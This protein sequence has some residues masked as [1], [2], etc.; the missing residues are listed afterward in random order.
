LRSS[1]YRRVAKELQE[2]LRIPLKKA[3]ATIK[4]STFNADFVEQAI[5]NHSD[6]TKGLRR[7]KAL[8]CN[9]RLKRAGTLVDKE[10]SYKKLTPKCLACGIRGHS[11]RDYWCLFK[12]KKPIGVIIRDT[13]INRA[14]KKVEKNK[15]LTN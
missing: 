15:N 12:D 9:R 5:K 7:G 8:A 10:T 6:T 3:N 1:K 11:L 4:G 2:G 14:L 13:R